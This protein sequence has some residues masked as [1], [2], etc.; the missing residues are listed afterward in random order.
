MQLGIGG[1][2]QV[3]SIFYFFISAANAVHLSRPWENTTGAPD[4]TLQSPQNM[5]RLGESGVPRRSGG[6]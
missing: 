5:N 1:T 3:P 2:F 6:G 4:D